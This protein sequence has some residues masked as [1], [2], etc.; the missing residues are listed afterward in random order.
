MARKY[1]GAAHGIEL[2]KQY[3]QHFLREQHVVDEMLAHVQLTPETNVFEIGCGDGFLTK[4]ILQTSVDRLWIF[5]IDKSWADYVNE[6]YPDIRM[7]IFTENIL[8]VDFERFE[9]FKPWTLLSNLPYQITFPLLKLMVKNRAILG[10]GVVMVQEE[11][12]QKIVAKVGDASWQSLYF[13]YYFMWKLLIK[14]P[15]GAFYPPPAVNSRLL[16]FKPKDSLE[17]IPDEEHFWKFV[18]ACFLQRRRTLKNNLAAIQFPLDL[19]PEEY[20]KAR[21]QELG[22]DDFLKLWKISQSN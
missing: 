18:K 6:T 9:Q 19:F 3:G 8:D 4:S 21:A 1:H 20:G 11:V 2:K 14:I 15:P 16:Y 12:A 17:P 13:G 10:E 5:E 22:L 7:T